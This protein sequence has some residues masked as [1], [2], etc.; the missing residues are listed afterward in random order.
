M[1]VR[2][3]NIL[4]ILIMLVCACTHEVL[5]LAEVPIAMKAGID[6]I[7]VQLKSGDVPISAEDDAYIG[8]VPSAERPLKVD[9]CFSLTSGVYSVA[10]PTDT[11]T[12]LP[13]HTTAIFKDE[14]ITQIYYNGENDKTLAYPTTGQDVYCVGFYPQ[15]TWKYSDDKKFKADLTG[16]ADL[17]FAPQISGKWNQQFGTANNFLV[18]QHMLTWLKVVICATSYD[19]IDAWGSITSITLNTAKEIELSP[20]DTIDNSVTFSTDQQ[21]FD[22]INTPEELSILK[23]DVG[24]VFIA[25]TSDPIKLT[26]KAEDGRIAT[27]DIMSTGGFRPGCQYV[28]VL[29]FDSLSV[30]DALCTLES[31]ENQNDNLYLE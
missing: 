6:N 9:L 5:P 13:C 1:K 10:T 28:M 16:K 30:V 17:M 24:S 27:V 20:I 4:F 31:W 12:Y 7:D 14:N 11:K 26:I 18:F 3:I 22:L 23:N 19:A 2:Y 25:P 29:Y 21:T 15:G 8:S